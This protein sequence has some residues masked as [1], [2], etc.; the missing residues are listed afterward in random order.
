VLSQPDYMV[1]YEAVKI[2]KPSYILECGTGMSTFVIAQSIK[3]NLLP[4]GKSCKLISMES[5]KSWYLHQK[6]IIKN[7]EFGD[8][9]EIIYSPIALFGYSFIRGTI[10]KD[11]PKY[12]YDL[13]FVDG[14]NQGNNKTGRMC[15]M[16][17]IKI[18]ENSENPITCI[19]DGR[20][21]TSLAYTQIFGGGGVVKWYPSWDLT[22]IKNVTKYDMILSRGLN[23]SNDKNKIKKELLMPSRGF[24]TPIV[25]LK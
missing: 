16:D 11:I 20:V 10:Y 3:D 5:E 18:I 25:N 6:S 22:I 21:H 14:P 13:V 17:F 1:L 24:K 9:V 8:F 23:D 7:E 15:N 12:P 19:I 2:Y 4:K